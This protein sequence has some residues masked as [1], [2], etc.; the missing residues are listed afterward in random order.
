[1]TVYICQT[2]WLGYLDVWSLL[3]HYISKQLSKSTFVFNLG[4]NYSYHIAVFCTW[5]IIKFI[6]SGPFREIR[7]KKHCQAGWLVINFKDPNIKRG[8][9]HKIYL[10]LSIPA[11]YALTSTHTTYTYTHKHTKACIFILTCTHT[12]SNLEMEDR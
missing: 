7:R 1:M 10:L 11:T 12:L 3:L 6:K 9:T 2:Y 8:L 4:G 5:L